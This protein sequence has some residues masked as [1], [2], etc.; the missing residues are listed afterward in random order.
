MNDWLLVT[1]QSESSVG[2]CMEIFIKFIAIFRRLKQ[3]SLS[4]YRVL[5]AL[6]PRLDERLIRP[7]LALDIA[8]FDT[9]MTSF[10]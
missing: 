10:K 8:V 9:N 7:R 3:I 5:T 4:I 2:C 6:Y 1:V